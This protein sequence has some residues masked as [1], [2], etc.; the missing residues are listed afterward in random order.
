MDLV[1]TWGQPGDPV[2]PPQPSLIVCI[3]S[4]HLLGLD[5]DAWLAGEDAVED[6][7]PIPAPEK[8]REF[9]LLHTD[10]VERV[11]LPS[12]PLREREKQMVLRVGAEFF[13]MMDAISERCNREVGR[14][15]E[16]LGMY[17]P[18]KEGEPVTRLT[19]PRLLTHTAMQDADHWHAITHEWPVLDAL[20]YSL[21]RSVAYHLKEV[22]EYLD[23]L[24]SP[25]GTRMMR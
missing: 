17:F 13:L 9:V 10:N 5:P 7:M 3:Q 16:S 8:A 6:D 18:D 15:K 22:H 14:L 21:H 4:L 12:Q 20:L 11:G 1:Y 2:A 24:Q 19:V 25:Q 23:D